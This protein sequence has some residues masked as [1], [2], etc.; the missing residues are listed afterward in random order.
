MKHNFIAC[1]RYDCG[2][3]E[4]LGSRTLSDLVD[5]IRDLPPD[6]ILVGGIGHRKD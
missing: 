1:V 3:C 6:A 5:Q 2:R 4:I